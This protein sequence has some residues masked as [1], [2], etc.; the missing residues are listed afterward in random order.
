[1][2]GSR[3]KATRDTRRDYMIELRIAPLYTLEDI[4]Q[5]F[6]TKVMSAHP[7]HSGSAREFHSLQTAYDKA[8]QYVAFRTDRRKWIASKMSEH[9]AARQAAERLEEFGAEVTTNAVDWLEK[10]FGDFSQL[11]ETITAVRLENYADADDMI[12][13]MVEHRDELGELTRLELPGCR[14]SSDSVQQ[15]EAFRQLRHLDL[16]GTPITKEALWIVDTI[17]G[18]ESMELKGTHIGWW[19]RRKVRSVLQNRREAKPVTPFG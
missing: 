5:A 8:K 12:L 14:V 3:S 13:A 2:A 11:T 1:M 9:L 10:L 18:L 4:N 7:D 6:R 15:L 17:L 16:S 19:M